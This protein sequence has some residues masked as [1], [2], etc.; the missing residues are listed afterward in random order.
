MNQLVKKLHSDN[1]TMNRINQKVPGTLNPPQP[2]ALALLSV[3]SVNRWELSE[4]GK[5][6][7]RGQHRIRRE[8][9]PHTSMNGG[10]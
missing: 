1:E 4:E 8:Y 6:G 9:Q 3:V 10:I 5:D 7:S 2:Q